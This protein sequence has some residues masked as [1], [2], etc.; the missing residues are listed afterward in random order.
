MQPWYAMLP[1]NF[2][3]RVRRRVPTGAVISGSNPPPV[4]IH[5]WLLSAY[6]S[7][8]PV[9]VE[10]A[11]P[12][13]G[14]VGR[15]YKQAK[16]GDE[17]VLT[18]E[19]GHSLQRAVF[20]SVIPSA[21]TRA[22]KREYGIPSAQREIENSTG[23]MQRFLRSWVFLDRLLALQKNRRRTF[24]G[25]SFVTG[26]Y[27]M[28]ERSSSK[29]ARGGVRHKSGDRYQSD[30]QQNNYRSHDQKNDRQGSDRQGGGGNYRNN[31]NNNYS[32]DN[33]RFP[34]GP[35]YLS[36]G[37]YS[38]SDCHH[39]GL[40]HPG[41]SVVVA[42]C[43]YFWL[44]MSRLVI[45]SGTARRTLVLVRLVHADKKQT[46]R[47][48]YYALTQDQAANTISLLTK[49]RSVNALPLDM[50][51]LT[52]ISGIDWLAAHRATIDCHSRRVIFGD[53][54]A[55]EFI[56]HGSLPGK[57]MK[58]ISAL[59]ARTLLSHGC[60]GF[61]AT[62]HDTTSDV[63]SIHDQPIVSEFQD[64]FPE[65]LP[66]IP[67]I[68]DVEFN[69]ELIP[70]A[71]PISKAPYRMAPIE[72]KELKDQL[73][74]LLERGFIRPSVSPWGAPVL[75]VKKKDGSMRLCID[76]R[77][78]NKITI[79]NRY[80]LPR[81]DDLFDQLQGAKHFSKIDLRSGYHQLRVKEQD[82]SKTSFST[83]YGHYEFLVMP[84][85]LT[86]APA[87]FMDL[88]NRVFHEFLDKF[89]IV[90]ID[91]ILV[92]SKSKEE[93]EEHL[94]TVLQILRQEKLYAKF[95]KCEFWLSKVAFLGHIVSTEG[96]TMDPAKVEAITKWPR[97][98]YVT[99]VRSFLGLAG[100]YRGFVE[101]SSRLALPLTKPMRKGEKFV[102]NEEREK[103]FE[104]LKQR[105]I[106]TPILTL[107]SD[108]DGFQI[109][110]NASFIR[111]L[112]VHSCS[113]GKKF[114]MFHVS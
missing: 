85:G 74:E 56:Y 86:N 53:I 75:F 32:R 49:I 81:I 48:V 100:Y 103:I 1:Q 54:H 33:N 24:V 69:I 97:P 59:K 19:L 52:I 72:L 34:A 65:E 102:W 7:R 64:V 41:G 37:I 92:F 36:E 17:W 57:S 78:L 63:S 40:R 113:M 73:Q 112:I 11:V 43:T 91:D 35:V 80:P 50:C 71:E 61:L 58:I 106:S 39:I 105:L 45:F 70:G 79:R 16:D 2:A 94:R 42:A 89:V 87:V 10:K 6:N 67:P 114:P 88:I 90:F 12:P 9:V 60:E 107:P 82:I 84:F 110:R 46:H 44:Q 18:F 22:L 30:T 77:E 23:Y 25:R 98:T 51:D 95:S 109:F 101:G 66:G 8:N 55:P 68:R 31:N 3:I 21:R 108:S 15:P 111:A 38:P 83:R 14:L 29:R 27:D 5:T 104:E 4:T 28:S 96:I 26:K 76:Y 13:L 20:S 62:I 99:E 93:H 47:P